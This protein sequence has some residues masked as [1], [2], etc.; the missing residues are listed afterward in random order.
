MRLNDDL[1]P[2]LQELYLQ[3]TK[4]TSR[5]AFQYLNVKFIISFQVNF[6]VN[7]SSKG[8]DFCDNSS[9]GFCLKKLSLEVTT[10]LTCFNRL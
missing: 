3:S 10:G 9:P 7:C 5:K 4:E 2:N 1:V 6:A 8:P